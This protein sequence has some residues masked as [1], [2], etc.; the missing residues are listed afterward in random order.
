MAVREEL[1]DLL[2][3]GRA[4]HGMSSTTPRRLVEVEQSRVR[5]GGISK[6]G[7]ATSAPQYAGSKQ[8]PS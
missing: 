3:P 1:H 5:A 6:S 8:Q 7:P 4:L 2:S